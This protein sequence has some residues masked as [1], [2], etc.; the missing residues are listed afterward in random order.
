MLTYHQTIEI[1][2]VVSYCNGA[3]VSNAVVSSLIYFLN[4]HDQS[5]ELLEILFRDCL[6]HNILILNTKAIK[7]FINNN[8][9]LNIKEIK[10]KKNPICFQHLTGTTRL[11]TS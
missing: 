10:S 2:E 3:Q 1:F 11:F 6:L 4:K 5:V 8:F 9:S 7:D